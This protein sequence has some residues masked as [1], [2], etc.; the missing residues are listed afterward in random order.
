MQDFGKLLL[1]IALGAL[2]L[3]HGIAKIRHGVGPVAGMVASAGLPEFVTW[4]VY[5]GEVVAPLMVLAGWFARIGAG[6]IAINM[7]FALALAHRGDFLSLNGM[8]GWVL[9]LQAMFLVT[10]VVIA[11]LGPGRYSANRR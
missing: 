11:L 9:E 6:I 8:G 3:L 10:A 2:I 1:R 5:V 4:G 7:V